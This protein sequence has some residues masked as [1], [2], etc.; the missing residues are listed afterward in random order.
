MKGDVMQNVRGNLGV[1]LGK[2]KPPVYVFAA[3]VAML[4]AHILVPITQV[5]VFPWTLLGIAPLFLGAALAVYAIRLFASHKTTPEPFGISGVLVTGGPF[6]VTRNPMYLGIILM[7]SGV[8][9]LF[10]TAGPWLVVPVLGIL[11]DVVFVRREEEKMEL[12]F[13]DAY[14]NYKNRVRRWI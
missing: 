4:A 13:G 3:L 14:R 6:R 7:V 8:A 11:L 5:I 9:A 12:L 10:G 1:T 2:K